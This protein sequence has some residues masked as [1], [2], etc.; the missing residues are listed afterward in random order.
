MKPHLL[1]S[2]EPLPFGTDQVALCGETVRHAEF[3]W[4]SDDARELFL[5]LPLRVCRKCL[6]VDL[7]KRYIYVAISGLNHE[8]PNVFSG[9]GP[10]EV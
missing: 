4:D 8:Q 9:Q 10:G 7:D 1:N 5:R 6:R 3:Q 2:D